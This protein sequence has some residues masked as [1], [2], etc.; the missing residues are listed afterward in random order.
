[1]QVTIY[2][3]ES[4]EY[5][6]RLVDAKSNQER[7]SRSAVIL[8]L[9]EEHFESG[10]RLGEIL[11]DLGVLTEEVLTRALKLQRSVG[12]KDRLLGEVLEAEQAVTGVEIKRALAIQ[13]RFN[14]PI[15]L[16]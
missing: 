14:E 3:A 6:L 12:F 7:K 11:V 5:L 1:M 8:S 15:Q 2:F 4:D 13:S 9:L 16:K 10:H